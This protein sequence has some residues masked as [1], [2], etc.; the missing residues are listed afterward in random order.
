MLSALAIKEDEAVIPARR[1]L[2]S[3]R[4]AWDWVNTALSFC[5]LRKLLSSANR[6]GPASSGGAKSPKR[7]LVV[8]HV[9]HRAGRWDLQA[10]LPQNDLSFEGLGRHSDLLYFFKRL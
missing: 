6:L 8:P 9:C 1:Y 2:S 10:D 3:P 7:F 4:F 5:K